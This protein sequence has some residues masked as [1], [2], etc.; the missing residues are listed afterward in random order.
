TFD[1]SMPASQYF[2]IENINEAYFLDN[3]YCTLDIDIKNIYSHK[4]SSFSL[5]AITF[6]KLKNVNEYRK[7]HAQTGSD[8]KNE[9]KK[10]TNWEPNEIKNIK[11]MIPSTVDNRAERFYRTP[12]EIFVELSCYA[13]SIEDEPE[14]VFARFDLIDLW[15]SKQQEFIAKGEL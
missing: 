4:F 3:G 1:E 5:S 2:K 12:E 15:K 14:G 13:I 7:S 10:I 9:Y 11:I 6:Y 8:I